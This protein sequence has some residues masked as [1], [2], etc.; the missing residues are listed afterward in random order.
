MA[1]HGYIRETKSTLSKTIRIPLE[2]INIYCN[3]YLIPLFDIDRHQI[4]PFQSINQ[5]DNKWVTLRSKN[6]LLYIL[7]H[8]VIFKYFWNHNLKNTENIHS[9]ISYDAVI[10]LKG[11]KFI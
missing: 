8:Y 4:K 11:S 7:T 5:R 10:G 3:Y 2:L 6:Q 9:N 1:V